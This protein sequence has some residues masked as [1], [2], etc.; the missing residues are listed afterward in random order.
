MLRKIIQFK[1]SLIF[2]IR[3]FPRWL[4][5][6]VIGLFVYIFVGFFALL[7]EI[8]RLDQAVNRSDL[9]LCPTFKFVDHLPKILDIFY[10]PL[11]FVKSDLP[12][13]R[14]V[15]DTKDLNDVYKDVPACFDCNGTPT[16]K[17]IPAKFYAEGKEYKVDIG[18]RG[19][20][21][22]HWIHPKKSWKILFDKDN[23]F[24]GNDRIDLVPPISRGILTTEL[25][26]FRSRKLGLVT[27]ESEFVNLVINNRDYG[28]YWE[29]EDLGKEV[30][31]KNE[32]NSDVNLYRDDINLARDDDPVGLLYKN[33]SYWNKKAINPADIV[34]NYAELDALLNL[35]NNSS[36]EEFNN[37]LPLIIDMENFYKWHIH[38]K[39]FG[40]YHQTY[41]NNAAI[42]FDRTLGK[43]K[44]IPD[45]AGIEPTRFNFFTLFS[46]LPADIAQDKN[47]NPLV[48]RVLLNPQF[49]KER[50]KILWEY[51][52][53]DKYLSEEKKFYNNLYNKTKGAFY[54]DN[55]KTYSNIYFDLY[56]SQVFK[57]IEENFNL[58]RELLKSEG[59]ISTKITFRYE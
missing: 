21:G 41:R 35:V 44:F 38:E 1:K 19:L 22:D 57:K 23:P 56:T 53:D 17:E 36:D 37:E 11:F 2:R 28:I 54:R 25:S 50:N 52:K 10:L 34:D 9:G 31:E 33:V 29:K 7:L 55:K 4:I 49:V 8:T 46:R 47:Y 26:A 20:C 18:L 13:Y 5:Y 27:P 24:K 48:T 16:N 12:Q 30:L 58:I 15:V 40:S 39:L 45:D 14:L 59:N 43:F 6:I 42:Y 51:V 32:Q 3:R